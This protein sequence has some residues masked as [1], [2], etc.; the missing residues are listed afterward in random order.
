MLVGELLDMV[1]DKGVETLDFMID[2]IT[3]SKYFDG[4]PIVSHLLCL[5]KVVM[6]IPNYL[7][8]KKTWAFLE[9]LKSRNMDC[10]TFSKAMKELNQNSEKFEEELLFQI[11]KAENTDKAKL[12]GYF[13]R[14]FALR[15][16]SYE[17][18][19][20]YIN[21]IN[22]MQLTFLQRF[23]DMYTDFSNLKNTTFYNILNAQ[24]LIVNTT[25][26]MSIDDSPL[27]YETDLSDEAK[28]FGKLLH[29]YFSM[30]E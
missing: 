4:F 1:E 30:K 6:V 3:E 16:I 17:N 23:S 10:D 19:L 8:A 11:E 22:N 25:P 26:Q 15:S 27:F 18:Y 2:K 9:G 20:F 21:V 24:G 29:N 28:D 7:Y 14:L 12:L 13:T 5:I